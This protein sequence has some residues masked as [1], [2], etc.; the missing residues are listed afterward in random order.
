[1][2]RTIGDLKLG[3]RSLATP[4]KHDPTDP[5]LYQVP[6]TPYPSRS[7]LV[8]RNPTTER[9]ESYDYSDILG[10]VTADPHEKLFYDVPD[11]GEDPITS[12][13]PCKEEESWEL[14]LLTQ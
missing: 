14:S 12:C 3:P 10:C 6:C 8:G 4:I 5:E 2:N 13:Y 7:A 11:G 1:M 9:S